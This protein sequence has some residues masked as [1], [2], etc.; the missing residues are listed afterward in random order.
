MLMA[1]SPGQ[2]Y[3]TA[4]LTA[5][6]GEKIQV[7]EQVVRLRRDGGARAAS[8]RVAGGDGIRLMEDIRNLIRGMRV[9]IE[10]HSTGQTLRARL[11]RTVEIPSVL[12]AAACVISSGFRNSSRRISPG[13]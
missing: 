2:H 4:R 9:S 5:L 13:G 12:A 1:D 10:A 8:L 6:V 3:R 11:R 7:G